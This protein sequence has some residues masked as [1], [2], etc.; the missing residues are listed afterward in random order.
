MLW[1]HVETFRIELGAIGH[2]FDSVYQELGHLAEKYVEIRS[3]TAKMQDEVKAQKRI[4]Q[5]LGSRIDR[6]YKQLQKHSQ[7]SNVGEDV[8]HK[9]LAAIEKVFENITG[10]PLRYIEVEQKL[11]EL[12]GYVRQ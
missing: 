8:T 4:L 1:T 10:Q 12:W 11:T 6:R 7:A 2:D 9:Q 5:E 3:Q